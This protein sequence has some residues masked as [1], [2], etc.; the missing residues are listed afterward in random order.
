MQSPNTD[1]EF[2]ARIDDLEAHIARLHDKL[3]KTNTGGGGIGCIGFACF[4][5]VLAKVHKLEG[6]I[7]ALAN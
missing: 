2:L 4:A 1:Q 6:L 7:Q 5:I 3:D